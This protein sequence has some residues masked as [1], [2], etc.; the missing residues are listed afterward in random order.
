MEAAE[1]S[2]F[3]CPRSRNSK[4]LQCRMAPGRDG[5]FQTERASSSGARA[6]VL[7][8]R[9]GFPSPRCK[10]EWGER[11]P[12][13]LRP[14]PPHA[15]LDGQDKHTG[16]GLSYLN[17]LEGRS[18]H[19][20]PDHRSLFPKTDRAGLERMNLSVI[21]TRGRVTRQ[22]G[23][24]ASPRRAG[25]EHGVKARGT[26]AGK[27]S[28]PGCRLASPPCLLAQGPPTLPLHKTRFLSRK[29]KDEAS[30]ELLGDTTIS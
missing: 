8:P 5:K 10:E 7:R 17:H 2:L 16:L 14:A 1:S 18:R 4:L 29:G 26:R 12:G 11:S 30:C 3:L 28:G 6:A 20:L 27:R 22:R 25:R 15:H 23:P 9:S 13:G 24:R 21:R 19:L